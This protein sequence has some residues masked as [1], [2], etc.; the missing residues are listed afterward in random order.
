M[1]GSLRF[2]IIIF[3]ITRTPFRING[4]R[5]AEKS[6]MAMKLMILILTETKLPAIFDHSPPSLRL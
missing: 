5:F 1:A 4:S 3:I 2:T 6:E